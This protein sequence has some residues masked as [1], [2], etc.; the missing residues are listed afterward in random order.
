MTAL[1]SSPCVGKNGKPAKSRTLNLRGFFGLLL[2][3]FFCSVTLLAAAGDFFSFARGDFNRHVGRHLDDAY[4]PRIQY[5][6][7]HRCGARSMGA[8]Y[9][10]L[11]DTLFRS[12]DERR[13]DGEDAS[14]PARSAATASEG[15]VAALESS[16]CPWTRKAAGR[17]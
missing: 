2:I 16:R 6:D 4:R 13:G 9:S 3:C 14:A 5:L 15:E 1:I 11:T 12:F 8:A 10:L 7:S 17:R